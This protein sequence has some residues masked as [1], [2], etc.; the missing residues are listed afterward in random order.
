M[1]RF[2]NSYAFN[3][4]VDQGNWDR[5]TRFAIVNEAT[6]YNLSL[7]SYDREQFV[8]FLEQI[9]PSPSA[10]TLTCCEDFCGYRAGE[11][12]RRMACKI[13]EIFHTFGPQLNAS[14]SSLS[15]VRQCRI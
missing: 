14:G 13:P 15:E 4:R 3:L 12:R 6:K 2:T 9:A 7:G 5:E 1:H 10:H 11:W 8:Y